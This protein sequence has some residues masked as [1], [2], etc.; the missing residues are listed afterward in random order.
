[1]DQAD[2]RTLGKIV[3]EA[4]GDE[5]LDLVLD[6]C[7]HMHDATRASFNELFSRLRPGGLCPI[8][9]RAWAHPALAGPSPDGPWPERIPLTR[10]IFELVLA[11]RPCLD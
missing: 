4:F 6:D 1:V 10:L 7:S 2:R 9:D 5:R 11:A 3:T 8:E